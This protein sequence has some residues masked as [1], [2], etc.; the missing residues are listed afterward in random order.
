MKLGLEMLVGCFTSLAFHGKGWLLC[1]SSS[2]V[3][4]SESVSG[5]FGSELT[6]ERPS[7]FFPLFTVCVSR[8][9]RV[10]KTGGQ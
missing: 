1:S 10:S 2:D 8:K 9:Y 6:W 4:T 7:L 3:S 5:W